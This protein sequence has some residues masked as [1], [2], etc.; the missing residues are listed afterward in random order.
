M[1]SFKF[2]K[3]KTEEKNRCEKRGEKIIQASERRL[4]ANGNNKRGQKEECGYHKIIE[5]IEKRI[6]YKNI[7]ERMS[8]S[9]EVFELLLTAAIVGAT[10]TSV[11]VTNGQWSAAN[12]QLDVMREQNRPWIRANISF[13][14]PIMFTESAGD[15][16]INVSL[17]FDLKNFGSSPATN[18]KIATI[19]MPHPGNAN[20]KIIDEAQAWMCKQARQMADSSQIGGKTVFP[21]E[22]AFVETGAGTGRIPGKNNLVIYSIFGC[23]YYTYAD[24]RHGQTGFR[25]ILGEVKGNLVVGIPFVLG[26]LEPYDPP[27]SDELLSSGYPKDPAIVAKVPTDDLLFRDDEGGNYAK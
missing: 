18:I 24:N 21:S 20:T 11:Y 9:K 8:K 2:T 3:A 7:R 22:P 19:V 27:L 13:S 23:I 26:K 4:D 1:L 15:R 10:W 5:L 25:K 16:F 14:Q 6:F 12:N 17:H